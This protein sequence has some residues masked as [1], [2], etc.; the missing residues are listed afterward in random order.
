MKKTRNIAKYFFKTI[1]WAAFFSI[2]AISKSLNAQENQLLPPVDIKAS[3]DK[4]VATVGD[5]I[6]FKIELRTEK[7]IRPQ[8]PTPLKPKEGL[9]FIK[10]ETPEIRLEGDRNIAIFHYIFRADLVGRF[11]IPSIKIKFLAPYSKTPGSPIEGSITSPETFVEVQSVL[12]TKEGPPALQDIKPLI[13]VERSWIHYWPY[14]LAAILFFLLTYYFVKKRKKKLVK[15]QFKAP[16]LIPCHVL[17]LQELE[18]LQKKNLL[19]QGAVR[20]YYF[21]LSEIF[22]K[23]L[24]ARYLFPALDRTRQEI[25]SCLKKNVGVKMENHLQSE[26]EFILEQTDKVKFAKVAPSTQE[27]NEIMKS[28]TGFVKSTIPIVQENHATTADTVLK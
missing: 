2:L 26:V 9:I 7:D 4:P 13:E 8:E 18:A 17:A 15:P 28:V 22:R 11:S 23:Y 14:A 25:F 16:K 12:Q 6:R 3:V 20:E 10:R 27:S 21:E 19:S 24:G 5:L 1:V